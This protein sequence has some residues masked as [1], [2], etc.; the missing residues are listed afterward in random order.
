MQPGVVR[1]VLAVCFL[2]V[3]VV[4]FLHQMDTS[5]MGLD[6]DK[7]SKSARHPGSSS[8][9]ATSIT[10]NTTTTTTTTAPA[11]AHPKLTRGDSILAFGDS[12]TQ[13]FVKHGTEWFPYTVR[14][15][16]LLDKQFGSGSIRVVNEGVSGER[17]DSMVWRLPKVLT[18]ALAAGQN[19]TAIVILGG[20]NDIF[21]QKPNDVIAN[22]VTLRVLSKSHGASV[23]FMT[24]PELRQEEGVDLYIRTR[25][26]INDGLR[27]TVCANHSASLV[28]LAALIPQHTLSA[29]RRKELWDP[30]LVHFSPQGYN[31]M[32]EIVFAALQDFFGF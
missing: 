3:M 12:L 14:L 8:N 13:G 4:A 1:T 19:F 2:L 27:D 32:G 9:N 22:L 29:E 28:D 10:T 17:T 30:D 31:K 21:F 7:P 5:M 23:F 26:T 11:V 6:F 24:V 25:N 20:T 18:K 15:Q 16:S